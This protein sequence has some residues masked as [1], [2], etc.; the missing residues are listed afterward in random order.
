MKAATGG[1]QAEW[2]EALE[3]AENNGIVEVEGARLQF[4]HPLFAAAVYASAPAGERRRV[5]RRLASLIPEV[6]ER[7]RHLAVQAPPTI[8]SGHARPSLLQSPVHSALT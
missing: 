6:E 8:V 7:A 1:T 5:H 4:A 3:G 2:R